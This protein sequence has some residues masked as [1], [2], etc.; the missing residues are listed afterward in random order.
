MDACVDDDDHR[1]STMS[2]TLLST[3]A[4]APLGCK[5]FPHVAIPSFNL[6]VTLSTRAWL[7]RGG[8][9]TGPSFHRLPAPFLAMNMYLSPLLIFLL[10]FLTLFRVSSLSVIWTYL[11]FINPNS[12]AGG[13]GILSGLCT[14][15]LGLITADFCTEALV[16]DTTP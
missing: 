16:H 2:R 1:A 13:L 3:P 12:L 8:A 5:V 6:N 11:V 7:L 9:R 4:S 10:S 15:S 14:L